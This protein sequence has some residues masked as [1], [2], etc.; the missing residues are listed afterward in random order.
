M[1]MNQSIA[2]IPKK[3]PDRQY[4]ISL[5]HDWENKDARDK[6]LNEIRSFDKDKLIETLSNLLYEP[7]PYLQSYAIDVLMTLDKQQALS[8]LLPLLN[9]PE[10][11]LRWFVCDLLADDGDERAVEPLTKVLLEDPVGGV[12]LMAAVALRHIGDTRAIPSLQYAMN[13][14][15]GTDDEGRRVDKA[16]KEAI[17]AILGRARSSE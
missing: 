11:G 13:H 4:I 6:I 8:L 12:R 9:A 7:D 14:D 1:I 17:D 3:F 2:P 16:A 5:L 10:A 15:K